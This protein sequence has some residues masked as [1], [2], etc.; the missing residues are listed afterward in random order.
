M[1]VASVDFVVPVGLDAVTPQPMPI[2]PS[3]TIPWQQGSIVA[4]VLYNLSPYIAEVSGILNTPGFVFLA[5]GC[6]QL[7]PLDSTAPFAINAWVNPITAPPATTPVVLVT[8]ATQDID[9]LASTPVGNLGII[10]EVTATVQIT[11]TIVTSPTPPP[12]PIVGQE[13]FDTTL[14]E[15]GVFG[16]TGW[17]YLTPLPFALQRGSSVIVTNSAGQ[18]TITFP[19]AFNTAPVVVAGVKANSLNLGIAGGPVATTT[20]FLVQVLLPG[21]GPVGAGSGVQVNWIAV[22]T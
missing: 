21:G 4:A 9:E 6:A 1:A 17:Q 2:I 10:G 18:A 5:P 14:N 7:F 12:A 16:S 8:Y 20:S 11:N 19:A 3:P 13:Y 15:L 22:G